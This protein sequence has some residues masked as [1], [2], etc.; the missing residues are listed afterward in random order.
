VKVLDTY[1]INIFL[2]LRHSQTKV[3]LPM[4]GQCVLKLLYYISGKI[5]PL[6]T[7]NI[8]Q[9]LKQCSFDLWV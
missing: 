8:W 9:C 7:E 1:G 6:L 5:S 2:T 3:S 4:R